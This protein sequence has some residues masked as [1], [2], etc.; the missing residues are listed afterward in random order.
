MSAEARAYKSHAAWQAKRAGLAPL[1]GRV[2]LAM[3][4]HPKR[5]KRASKA[6]TRCIDLDNALKVAIDALNGVAYVDDSQVVD[7]HIVRGE[8]VQDGAIAVQVRGLA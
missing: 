6:E 2:T 3:T 4:L 7:L 5:P 8:P 1:A